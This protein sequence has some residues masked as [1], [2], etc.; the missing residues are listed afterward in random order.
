MLN[1]VIS[2]EPH[3]ES[4]YQ[5]EFD[6]MEGAEAQ[7][8]FL[9]KRYDF[10]NVR[11]MSPCEN[12]SRSR[13]HLI[14]PFRESR[15]LQQHVSWMAG[16]DPFDTKGQLPANMPASIGEEELHDEGFVADHAPSL[17]FMKDITK[18]QRF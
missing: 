4:S 9:V 7:R 1:P 16:K 18:T 12:G 17:Q 13:H 6:T 5:Y 8:A 11:F 2:P 10:V 3:T 14:L 15:L